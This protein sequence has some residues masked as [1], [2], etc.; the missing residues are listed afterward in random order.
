M[1]DLDRHTK[2]TINAL[3]RLSGRLTVRLASRHLNPDAHE[4]YRI[5]GLVPYYVYHN[6]PPHNDITKFMNETHR[7]VRD[8]DDYLRQVDV[9]QD[10]LDHYEDLAGKKHPLDDMVFCLEDNIPETY[11]PH[12]I[13]S[14]ALA[15]DSRASILPEFLAVQERYYG[16]AFRKVGYTPSLYALTDTNYS[17]GVSNVERQQ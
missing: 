12:P 16:R 4:R 9:L 11:N 3:D 7:C 2:L 6:L 8:D 15:S 5:L 13:N 10:M 14:C 1:T 17:W